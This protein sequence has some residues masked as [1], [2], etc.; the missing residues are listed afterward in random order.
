MNVPSI[1]CHVSRKIDKRCN[2]P[3]IGDIR[4]YEFVTD[5]L[6]IQTNKLIICVYNVLK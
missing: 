3:N 4:Y 1:T 6:K 5:Y 2:A